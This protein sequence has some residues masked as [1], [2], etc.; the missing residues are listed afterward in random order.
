MPK[1]YFE[2]VPLDLKIYP[3]SSQFTKVLVF[4]HENL[5]VGPSYNR[6]SLCKL[7]QHNRLD[8]WQMEIGSRVEVGNVFFFFKENAFYNPISL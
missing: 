7:P 6:V 4:I 8:I 3:H 2:L 1:D 5:T